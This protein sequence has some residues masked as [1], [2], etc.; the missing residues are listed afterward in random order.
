VSGQAPQG[1]L[2]SVLLKPRMLVL[3]LSIDIIQES[4]LSAI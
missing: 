2:A 3:R 4:V 1:R